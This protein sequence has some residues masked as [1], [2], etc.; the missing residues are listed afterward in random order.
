ME[1]I[2]VVKWGN[3]DT[4]VVLPSTIQWPESCG[5]VKCFAD[6][7][8]GRS[9]DVG[10]LFLGEWGTLPG[11]CHAKTI[12]FFYPLTLSVNAVLID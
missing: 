5:R 8:V 9:V 7:L 3:F 11:K 10:R 1:R 2:L 6:F 4:A 12:L